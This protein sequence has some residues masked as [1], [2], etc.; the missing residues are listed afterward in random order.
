GAR[1]RSPISRTASGASERGAAPGKHPRALSFHP[2]CGRSNLSL[3]MTVRKHARGPRSR[4]VEWN[5]CRGLDA[6]GRTSG[7]ASMLAPFESMIEPDVLETPAVVRA[8][9]HDRDP[10]HPR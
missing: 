5:G 10:L 4:A 3:V 8:V 2:C 7:Q 6:S 1:R 9:G